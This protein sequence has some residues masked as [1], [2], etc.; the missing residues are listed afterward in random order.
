MNMKAYRVMAVIAAAAMLLSGK[1]MAGGGYEI[2]WDNDGSQVSGVPNIFTSD[3]AGNNALPAGDLVQLVAINGGTNVVLAASV[4]GQNPGALSAAGIAAPGNGF[5]DL[6]TL[7][8]SNLLQSVIG[9]PLGIAYYAGTTAAAASATVYTPDVVSPSPDWV[10]PP[11]SAVVV[12][13]DNG[14][15][16]D[17]NYPDAWVVVKGAGASAAGATPNGYYVASV[18]EPSSIAL[19]VMGL[20]GA[21]GM[22]RRRS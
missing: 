12:E 16:G 14:S 17:G 4:L 10:T 22:V 5:I 7:V 2:Q 21:I 9:D 8:A 15:P 1:V 6:E 11:T 20:L 3:A 19:V 13:P 18:P